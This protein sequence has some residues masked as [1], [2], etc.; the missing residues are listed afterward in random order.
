[1]VAFVECVSFTVII[2]PCIFFLQARGWKKEIDDMMIEISDDAVGGQADD[3]GGHAD[4][5]GGLADD[6]GG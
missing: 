6:V 3:V 4:D 2:S 5:I 1:M